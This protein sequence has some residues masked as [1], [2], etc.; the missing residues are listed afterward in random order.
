MEFQ[1]GGMLTLMIIGQ[2]AKFNNKLKDKYN[3]KKEIYSKYKKAYEDILAGHN[4]IRQQFG[5]DLVNPITTELSGGYIPFDPNIVTTVNAMDVLTK[6][7]VQKIKDIEHAEEVIEQYYIEGE[8]VKMQSCLFAYLLQS[9]KITDGEKF[10]TFIKDRYNKPEELADNIGSNMPPVSNMLK[11]PDVMDRAYE[12]ADKFIEKNIIYNKEDLTEYNE[13]LKELKSGKCDKDTIKKIDK[14]VLKPI[15]KKVRREVLDTRQKDWE[16]ILS[17]LKSYIATQVSSSNETERQKIMNDMLGHHDPTTAGKEY[18]EALKKIFNDNYSV[19]D[20]TLTTSLNK[21]LDKMWEYLPSGTTYNINTIKTSLETKIN[22]Y[23]VSVDSI[24]NLINNQKDATT[25]DTIAKLYTDKIANITRTGLYTEVSF[26]EDLSGYPSKQAILGTCVTEEKVLKSIFDSNDDRY[27]YIFEIVQEKFSKTDANNTIADRINTTV[28]YGYKTDFEGYL[29]TIFQNPPSSPASLAHIPPNNITNEAHP[30]TAE[31]YYLV[32]RNEKKTEVQNNWTALLNAIQVDSKNGLVGYIENKLSDI[33]VKKTVEKIYGATGANNNEIAKATLLKI[34]QKK[35]VFVVSGTNHAFGITDIDNLENKIIDT[36]FVGLGVNINTFS[37][38]NN[39]TTTDYFEYTGNI[40]QYVAKIQELY[41][42]LFNTLKSTFYKASPNDN[43]LKDD[44]KLGGDFPIGKLEDDFNNDIMN[45]IIT[46][47]NDTISDWFFNTTT[48]SSPTLNDYFNNAKIKYENEITDNYTKFTKMREEWNKII[49]VSDTT[50]NIGTLLNLNNNTSN[51]KLEDFKAVIQDISDDDKKKAYIKKIITDNNIFGDNT[52]NNSATGEQPN[53][54]KTLEKMFQ[55]I[56]TDNTKDHYYAKI[57]N[58]LEKEIQKDIDITKIAVA[59]KTEFETQKNNLNKQYTIAWGSSSGIQK[60]SKYAIF[61]I[62]STNK[63]ATQFKYYDNVTDISEE[64]FDNYYNTLGQEK[65]V[66]TEL[67][68]YYNKGTKSGSQLFL[69][70]DAEEDSTNKNGFKD[71]LEKV[72]KNL[73]LVRPSVQVTKAEIE[74]F[75]I[76]TKWKDNLVQKFTNKVKEITNNSNYIAIAKESNLTKKDYSGATTQ[77]KLVAAILKKNDLFANLTGLDYDINL[78][79]I[80]QLQTFATNVFSTTG[81]TLYSVD[82][83]NSPNDVQQKAYNILKK[84]IDDAYNIA[85]QLYDFANKIHTGIDNGEII[86]HYNNERSKFTSTYEPKVAFPN[87]DYQ[88]EVNINNDYNQDY[89]AKLT[90]L[91]DISATISANNRTYDEIFN[92]YKE[93]LKKD[94]DP[95]IKQRESWHNALTSAVSKINTFATDSTTANIN[96]IRAIFTSS[97]YHMNKGPI[98]SDDEQ[99]AYIKD[100]LIDAGKIV[101]ATDADDTTSL[102]LTATDIEKYYQY[103]YIKYAGNTEENTNNKENQVQTRLTDLIQKDIDLATDIH[104]NITNLATGMKN[105]YIA[106]L[107]RVNTLLKNTHKIEKID[108]YDSTNAGDGNKINYNM[109]LEMY[110]NNTPTLNGNLANNNNDVYKLNTWT[111]NMKNIIT[112]KAVEKTKDKFWDIIGRIITKIDTDISAVTDNITSDNIH[113]FK[114]EIIKLFTGADRSDTDFGETDIKAVVTDTNWEIILTDKDT[115]TNSANTKIN[116]LKTAINN[117]TQRKTKKGTLE[118][119]KT[120][121]ETDKTTKNTELTKLQTN[122]GNIIVQ[123]VGTETETQIKNY[124]KPKIPTDSDKNKFLKI[125]LGLDD[126]ADTDAIADKI[127]ANITTTPPTTVGGFI[128]GVSDLISEINGFIDNTQLQTDITTLKKEIKNLDTQIQ[129]TT[130]SITTKTQEKQNAEQEIQQKVTDG[131]TKVDTFFNEFEGV[132]TKVKDLVKAGTNKYNDQVTNFQDTYYA[133]GSTD[134]FGHAGAHQKEQDIKEKYTTNKYK[135]AYDAYYAKNDIT[136]DD[137]KE[138]VSDDFTDIEN[139]I[140]EYVNKGFE[141]FKTIYTDYDVDADPDKWKNTDFY[142][143]YINN[144]NKY[145]KNA[146][147]AYINPSI[148]LDQY[149][150]TVESVLDTDGPTVAKEKWKTIYNQVKEYATNNL[151]TQDHHQAF[152]GLSNCTEPDIKGVFTKY[153]KEEKTKGDGNYKN[154]K[155]ILGISDKLIKHVDF[156]TNI[157]E[158]TY[159]HFLKKGADH[160]Y[161]YMINKVNKIVNKQPEDFYETVKKAQD[162]INN[163][164]NEVGNILGFGDWSDNTG[165]NGFLKEAIGESGIQNVDGITISTNENDIKAKI[166]ELNKDDVTPENLK[167]IIDY[168]DKYIKIAKTKYYITSSD[169]TKGIIKDDKFGNE[170]ED[171]LYI[172]KLILGKAHDANI[173]Y[174]DL[175]NEWVSNCIGDAS[176]TSTIGGADGNNIDIMNTLNTEAEKEEIYNNFD[177]TKYETCIAEYTTTI[178]NIYNNANNNEIKNA[179]TFLANN[180]SNDLGDLAIYGEFDT[181]NENNAYKKAHEDYDANYVTD[182]VAELENKGVELVKAKFDETVQEIKDKSTDSDKSEDV[183]V[184][185]VF[186]DVTHIEKDTIIDNTNYTTIFPKL[187][188]LIEKADSLIFK[189]GVITLKDLKDNDLEEYKDRLVSLNSRIK[190]KITDEIKDN[191]L[192]YLVE[193]ENYTKEDITK[194]INEITKEKENVKTVGTTIKQTMLN[195]AA[196]NGGYL[197]LHYINLKGGGNFN[198]IITDVT[199]ELINDTNADSALSEEEK[200][201]KI[202]WY[203]SD[204]LQNKFKAIAAQGDYLLELVSDENFSDAID[205]FT[206]QIKENTYLMTVKEDYERA[207]NIAKGGD[208]QAVEKLKLE[209]ELTQAVHKKVLEEYEKTLQQQPQNGGQQ[210]QQ[211]GISDPYYRKYKKYKSL[212]LKRKKQLGGSRNIDPI[213]NLLAILKSNNRYNIDDIDTLSSP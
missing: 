162:K 66:K 181:G 18:D 101:F 191:L 138:Q 155:E 81:T 54:T 143:K 80:A 150:T 175:I 137:Y 208:P 127:Y 79:T 87:T 190:N 94:L 209:E 85:N 117:Y 68:Q 82:L 213:K 184:N 183:F 43:E 38:N 202:A 170:R 141:L 92:K 75:K 99:K 145:K 130:T 31:M 126:S 192:D 13:I 119:Q 88:K 3:K 49:N 163:V 67:V 205:Y 98:S 210:V 134:I 77:D 180:F 72:F 55:Y 90:K 58:E 102:S 113:K 149:K 42:D 62:D 121:L 24:H 158:D 32:K 52:T 174:N 132:Y 157:T 89:S 10:F 83:D 4:V 6:K 206:K 153:F 147:V 69:M 64:N 26:G 40:G 211:G 78:S 152:C 201:K 74:K 91:A 154:M 11:I 193:D 136:K 156:V 17:D 151:K 189:V 44:I 25:T 203:R 65:L 22:E 115:K 15:K 118:T 71:H 5:L 178:T 120:G 197:P 107:N 176:K 8:R 70:K 7:A 194:K 109:A 139:E 57:L 60:D 140:E 179:Y 9:K 56:D 195:I 95:F 148:D 116:E 187:K 122:L 45:I 59:V 48:V 198:N 146:Y 50:T 142:D 164:S 108:E 16:N 105:A 128:G 166:I 161:N 21:D 73:E 123:N 144:T 34:V 135:A 93:Q 30:I 111:T 36:N 159:K 12:L 110:K 103:M 53:Y 199:N 165:K 97:D 160:L 84:G 1:S 172:L 204:E 186:G 196:Q 96:D 207:I 104:T 168:V 23:I 33:K 100:K 200:Q 188:E 106:E 51:P 19:F 2:L 61:P 185:E 39:K 171:K 182:A 47:N 46:P 125:Y 86:T 37:E 35:N 114:N 131:K 63:Y 129:T 124:I 41:T 20:R 14:L 27:D 112:T 29:N 177:L 173:G 28:L 133:T 169:E 212:Y 76:D 167:K